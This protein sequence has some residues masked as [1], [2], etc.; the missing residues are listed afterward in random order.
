MFVVY[1]PP[2][3]LSN[4]KISVLRVISRE[5]YHVTLHFE[6]HKYKTDDGVLKIVLQ[7]SSLKWR[8]NG[9]QRD[10]FRSIKNQL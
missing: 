10:F 2:L 8:P 5:P 3:P 9:F 6:G 1:P 4:Y 7:C